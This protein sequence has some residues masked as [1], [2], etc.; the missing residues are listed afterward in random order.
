MHMTALAAEN[1]KV[2][3]GYWDHDQHAAI[4]ALWWTTSQQACH[5]G[6]MHSVARHKRLLCPT[7][8]MKA[9]PL[10]NKGKQRCSA[11][12]LTFMSMPS[13]SCSVLPRCRL[14][15]PVEALA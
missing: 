10:N 15:P 11:R 13:T 7:R 14:L 5:T 8:D 1:E 3:G 6:V 4:V 12:G 9:N 2:T